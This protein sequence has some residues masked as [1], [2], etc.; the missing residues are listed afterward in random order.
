L[1]AAAEDEADD[2]VTTADPSPTIVSARN[3][4]A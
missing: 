3:K 4:S 2:V 1:G